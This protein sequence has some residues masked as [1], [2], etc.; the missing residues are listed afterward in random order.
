VLSGDEAR[1]AWRVLRLRAGDAAELFDGRGG[2]ATAR[3]IGGGPDRVELMVLELREIARPSK[4]LHVAVA[5][6]KG[7]RADWLIEKLAEFGVTSL[8]PLRAARGVSIPAATRIERWNRKAEA[9]AKQSGASFL[10]AVRPARTPAELTAEWSCYDRVL[11]AD[12]SP[13]AEWLSAGIAALG[14]GATLALI[15]PE[16]GFT[17][18]EQRIMEAAGARRVR[19]SATVL[20]IETAALAMAA[21]WAMAGSV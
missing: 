18:D 1:H 2:H 21:A 13:Q 3:V 15:G 17:A 11:L 12:P 5:L 10:L 7:E 8:I 20:R 4:S 14:G 6:P 9:A 19:L 16:G